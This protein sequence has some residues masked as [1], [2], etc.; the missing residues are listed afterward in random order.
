MR[1]T[2]KIIIYNA[3]MDSP[4]QTTCHKMRAYAKTKTDLCSNLVQ[5]KYQLKRYNSI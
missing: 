2:I 5:N 4:S 1:N 3:I